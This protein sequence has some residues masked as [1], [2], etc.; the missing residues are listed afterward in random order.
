MWDNIFRTKPNKRLVDFDDKAALC[1]CL[2][3]LHSWFKKHRNEDS[4]DAEALDREPDEPP[5]EG[6]CPDES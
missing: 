2:A 6:E 4:D 5:V 1:Q 3:H